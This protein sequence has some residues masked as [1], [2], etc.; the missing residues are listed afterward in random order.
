MFARFVFFYNKGLKHVA[1]ARRRAKSSD[2]FNSQLL[3]S[4][5]LVLKLQALHFVGCQYVNRVSTTMH[6]MKPIS[7]E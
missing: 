1:M 7:H 5:A 6:C 2:S 3:F 4:H